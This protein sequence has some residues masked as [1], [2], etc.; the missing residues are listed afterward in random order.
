MLDLLKFLFRDY[1]LLT[2]VGVVSITLLIYLLKDQKSTKNLSR[3]YRDSIFETQTKIYLN[4][5]RHLISG[6]REQAIQD[7]LAALEVSKEALEAYFALGELFRTNGEIDKAISVH[8]SIIARENLSESARV[9]ALKELALDYD[10]GGLM[11]KAIDSYKDLL[12]INKEDRDCIQSLCTIFEAVEDWDDAIKYRKLLSKVT[13]VSQDKTISHILIQKGYTALYEGDVN[14]AIELM[15][16]AISH[17]PSLSVKVFSIILNLVDGD[18]DQAKS[19]SHDFLNEYPQKSR[20]LLTS[21][22]ENEKLKN[23]F[24]KYETSFESLIS[25]FLT[26][27]KDKNINEYDYMLFKLYFIQRQ[28]EESSNEEKLLKEILKNDIPVKQKLLIQIDLI[29]ALL[30]DG[31]VEEAKNIISTMRLKGQDQK[32]INQCYNCGYESNH[33]FWRCPQC[34]QWETINFKELA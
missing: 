26:S 7:F 30:Q 6:D 16:A 1:L 31:K 20:V 33:Y 11:D 22:K 13:N 5:T 19:L 21:L 24:P 28:E 4:A 25:Y 23:H 12:L 2:S 32:I 29:D 10:E 15:N 14:S 8:Q 9:R 27:F 3:K 18:T 17:A 34:H